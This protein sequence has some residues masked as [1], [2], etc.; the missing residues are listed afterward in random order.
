[1]PSKNHPPCP[2]DRNERRGIGREDLLLYR[3]EA[4]LAAPETLVAIDQ[5]LQGVDRTL[6][7]VMQKIFTGVI[8]GLIAFGVIGLFIGPV[9][10]TAARRGY[11]AVVLSGRTADPRQ[12]VDDFPQSRNRALK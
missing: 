6:S 10:R 9:V 11:Y 7:K 5:T 1:M 4:D 12:L 3:R 2:T 8:G